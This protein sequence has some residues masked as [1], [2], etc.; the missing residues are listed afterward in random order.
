L[1][2]VSIESFAPMIRIHGSVGTGAL[3]N[4]SDVCTV[5]TLL[6]DCL[7]L[8]APLR[9][10]DPTGK[11]D[12]HTVGAIRLFQERVLKM[13]SPDGRVDP[14]GTTLRALVSNAKYESPF[15]LFS[16]PEKRVVTGI[17]FPLSARPA[18]SYREGMRRFG[19]RRKG[20]RLH[21]GC[22]LYAPVGTPILALDSGVVVKVYEFYLGTFALEVRH[23]KFIARYGEIKQGL[24][25]GVYPD[26]PVTRG[27]PIAYVGKLSGLNMSMLHL[28]LYSGS[29]KGP[30]STQTGPYKRRAD[31]IDPTSILDGA[32]TT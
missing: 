22:D 30:L 18:E 7:H 20:G 11:P 5:Q 15:K 12:A 16:V 29:A 26:K 32:T 31:L 8:L 4:Y 25:P 6:N 24:A 28:E 10:L 13:P 27:Q 3:N 14:N 17:R 9:E 2:K 23:P 19:A 1:V 21:A